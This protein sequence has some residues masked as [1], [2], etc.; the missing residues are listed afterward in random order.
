MRKQNAGER[1]QGDRDDDKR[2]AALLLMNPSMIH[3]S[4]PAAGSIDD[5]KNTKIP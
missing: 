1:D 2:A 4:G 5:R 3:A